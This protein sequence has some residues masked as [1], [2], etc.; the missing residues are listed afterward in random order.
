MLICFFRQFKAFRLQACDA[1]G[2]C[3]LEIEFMEQIDRNINIFSP[4]KKM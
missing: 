4:D 2:A 1:V 3:H